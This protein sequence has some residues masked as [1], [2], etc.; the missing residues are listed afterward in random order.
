MSTAGFLGLPDTAARFGRLLPFALRV[1]T[2]LRSVQDDR[3]M[4]LTDFFKIDL[5]VALERVLPA[6][7]NMSVL[8][9]RWLNILRSNLNRHY[10]NF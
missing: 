6:T 7:R 1:S 2:P 9:E 8:T 5:C 3:G 4:V 10:E